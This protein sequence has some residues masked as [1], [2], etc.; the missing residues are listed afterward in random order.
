MEPCNAGS[1]CIITEKCSMAADTAE[2]WGFIHDAVGRRPSP[3]K[4]TQLA[5]WPDYECIDDVRSHVHF[6]EYLK[7]FIPD[8][9]DVI[10]PL[11]KY[12]KK[13][14]PNV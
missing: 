5:E 14:A 7:E 10:L 3:G 12:L 1:K 13:G 11:R 6:V 4:V 2:Y 9:P 8:L